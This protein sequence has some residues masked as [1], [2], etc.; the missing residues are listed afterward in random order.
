MNFS[1]YDARTH[2]R[3]HMHTPIDK[4]GEEFLALKHMGGHI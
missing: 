2:A 4:G 3:A 1:P